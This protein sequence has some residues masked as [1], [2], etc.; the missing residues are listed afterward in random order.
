MTIRNQ[1]ERL[2][3]V[4]AKLGKQPKA[5]TARH[6]RSD[7]EVNATRGRDRRTVLHCPLDSRSLTHERPICD[8]GG[9]GV[10]VPPS[11]GPAH[12]QTE[13]EWP[14]LGAGLQSTALPFGVISSRLQYHPAVLASL[15]MLLDPRNWR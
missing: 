11:Q 9:G 15:E 5:P 2:D 4:F 1:I 12:G 13:Y 14:W 7:Q 6:R 3:N 8:T 10:M